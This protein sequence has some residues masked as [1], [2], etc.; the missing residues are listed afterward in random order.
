V[1]DIVSKK[2]DACYYK[3][4]K[5]YSVF[6][7]ARASQALAKCRKGKG[8]VRKTEK[9]KSLKR[10]EKE[11]WKDVRTG[12]P[13]GEKTKGTPYCRPSKRVSSKTPKTSGEMSKSEK[14]RKVREK[15]SVGR[16]RKV[17][18]VDRRGKALARRLKK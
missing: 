18:A 11:E 4:K 6:P 1:E 15:Q 7:S 5:Q 2:K 12:K 10:W 16:G 17:K 13:C 14:S 8:Q 3:I 9:G